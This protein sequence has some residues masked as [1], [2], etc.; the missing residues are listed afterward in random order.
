MEPA[1]EDDKPVFIGRFNCGAISLHLPMILAKAK[2]EGK[3]FYEVLDYYLELIRN[4]HKR[5]YDYLG[6]M[7]ASINPL[8]CCEG[9]FYG[10]HLGLHDKIR[11]LLKSSTFSFGVTALN[12]LQQLYN[13]KS[14]VEDGEFAIEVM[15]YIN[16]KLVEFKKEDD[17]LYAI[18]GG[19]R[20]AVVKLSNV[21]QRCTQ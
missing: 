12:E 14:L 10:G 18:Y 9:G 3:D 15:K 16:K 8:M 2:K 7:R 11:P 17:I 19:H 21:I 20:G 13:K 1:D 5:T 4:L 6:E